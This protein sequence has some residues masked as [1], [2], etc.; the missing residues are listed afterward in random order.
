MCDYAMKFLKKPKLQEVKESC[1]RFPGELQDSEISIF[2]V[3]FKKSP[4]IEKRTK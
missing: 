1:N 4:K 2:N 3:Y